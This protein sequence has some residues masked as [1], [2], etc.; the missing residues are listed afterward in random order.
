MQRSR[1]LLFIILAALAT[2][3]FLLLDGCAGEGSARKKK[4]R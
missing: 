2:V 4:G 1:F 3:V